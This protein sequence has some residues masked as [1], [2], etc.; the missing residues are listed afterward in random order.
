VLAVGFLAN[1]AIR[2]VPER[3]HEPADETERR[4]VTA[5]GRS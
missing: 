4:E 2:P 1:L 3:Y 5:G